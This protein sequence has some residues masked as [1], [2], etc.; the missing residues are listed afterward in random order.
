M[1]LN[2][3]DV[4]KKLI[5]AEENYDKKL[6]DFQKK[7]IEEHKSLY[8]DFSKNNINSAE[9]LIALSQQK[10]THKSD[11]AFDFDIIQQEEPQLNLAATRIPD[12][13]FNNKALAYLG[14]A[15]F[16]FY[17]LSVLFLWYKS[18]YHE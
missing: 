6:K 13:S 5:E 16:V 12:V 15:F 17:S 2:P 8:P 9:M 7:L 10:F 3:N 11:W 4:I 1:N 14:I 18:F